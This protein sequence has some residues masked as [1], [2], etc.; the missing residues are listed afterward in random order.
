MTLLLCYVRLWRPQVGLPYL[1]RGEWGLRN[2]PA[3]LTRDGVHWETV[4]MLR[5]RLTGGF[6]GR[7]IGCP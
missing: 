5:V 4:G 2:G 7:T 6:P 3:R 1:E